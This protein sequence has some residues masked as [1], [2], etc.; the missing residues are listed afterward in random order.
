MATEE[1][2]EDITQAF[3]RSEV[4]EHLLL[5]RLDPHRANTELKVHHLT[6]TTH[7]PA[8]PRTTV[9]TQRASL[10]RSSRETA[11]RYAGHRET[12][13]APPSLHRP[14][15]SVLASLARDGGNIPSLISHPWRADRRAEKSLGA[16]G[17]SHV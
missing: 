9:L 10:S 8:C 6:G 13:T 15:R 17:E 16:R 4:S 3:L 2:E 14:I 12:G 5:V 1:E 7:G 11:G